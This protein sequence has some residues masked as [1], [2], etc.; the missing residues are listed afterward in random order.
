[1]MMD[2]EY[3]F[4][5]GQITFPYGS[6]YVNFYSHSKERH[7]SRYFLSTLVERSG[8]QVMAEQGK[9]YYEFEML[10]DNILSF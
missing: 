3:R 10:S 8:G 4:G 5:L 7:K 6:D 2:Q 9:I 1:M